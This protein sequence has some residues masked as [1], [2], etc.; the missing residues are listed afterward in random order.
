MRRGTRHDPIAGMRQCDKHISAALIMANRAMQD[1]QKYTC[2]EKQRDNDIEFSSEI[3]FA[4]ASLRKA[5]AMMQETLKLVAQ[6]T[7]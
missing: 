7:N 5:N 1:Y 2:L 6:M 4:I 3:T